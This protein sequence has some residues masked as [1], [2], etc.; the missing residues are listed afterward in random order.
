MYLQHVAL[1]LLATLTVACSDS[2]NPTTT[3]PA[4][5]KIAVVLKSF[6]NPFFVEMAKGARLAQTETGI[7]LEI[8]VATPDTSTEQQI[9]LVR[10][11]IIAGVNAIVIS[12]VDTQLLVP[13]LKAAYDAGIKIVNIDEPLHPDALSAAGLTSVPYV[14]VN[15]EQAAYRAAK[16][17]ADQIT[18]PTEVAIVEGLSGTATAIERYR[19]A[20]RAFQANPH[21]RLVQAGAAN[22]KADEA[23]ELARRLFTSHPKTGV[24]YCANDLMA[25][26]VIKYLQ[27]VG[28]SKVLVGGFDALEETKGAIRAGHMAVTVDQQASQ[29]GYLGVIS[30]VKL[31]R[32]EEV[33]KVL[34]VETKLV[35]AV[36]LK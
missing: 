35:S 19:G 34:L 13:I 20:Q 22:W 4:P 7:D 33:P 28:N 10:S 8:K 25:I 31:L 18:R 11:Q 17:M 6:T 14:G 27:E 32:A 26:G 24:V 23:Y 12:P 2:G 16:L 3:S 9:R 5:L 29:Q 15:S 21:L 30:A 36:G 1:L